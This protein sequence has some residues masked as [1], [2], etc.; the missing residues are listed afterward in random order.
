MAVGTGPWK[1]GGPETCWISVTVWPAKGEI[2]TRITDGSEAPWTEMDLL[3]G[4]WLTRQAVLDQ[5]GAT[6]WLFRWTDAL[7]H[8]FKL[9]T[10]KR[11]TR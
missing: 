3:G 4:Q 8:H 6:E 5:P 2:A 10:V 1:E 7:V 11:S 9:E